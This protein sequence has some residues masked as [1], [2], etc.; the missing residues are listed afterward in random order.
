MTP[1]DE[2]SKTA[3]WVG[4][5]IVLGG[6]IGFLLRPSVM[7]V[8]QLPLGIVI[9]RG[10][11]LNGFDSILIPAAQ[12]S[13]NIMAAGAIAG[14]ILGPVIGRALAGRQRT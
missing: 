6:W 5:G 4:A 1:E 12:T 2:G 9:S 10:A 13:F 8:G 7:L 14:A 11:T 3:L